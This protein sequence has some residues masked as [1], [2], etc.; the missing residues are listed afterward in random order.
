MIQD[1]LLRLLEPIIGTIRPKE[2][3]EPILDW[4]FWILDWSL[5]KH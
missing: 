5:D 3:G 4:E 1:C 2:K